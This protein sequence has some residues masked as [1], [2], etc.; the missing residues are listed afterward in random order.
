MLPE[1]LLTPRTVMIREF[2]R[3]NEAETEVHR[4]TKRETRP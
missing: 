4:K 3:C 2:I 1:L